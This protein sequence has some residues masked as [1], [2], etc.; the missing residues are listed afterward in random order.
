MFSVYS[1]NKGIG[2]T[3][4]I[5]LEGSVYTVG[6]YV[7]MSPTCL[8][9]IDIINILAM[10]ETCMQNVSLAQKYLSTTFILI[11][12]VKIDSVY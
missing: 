2:L 4:P 9:N 6:P 12:C 10:Y 1:K 3:V 11:K 7:V 5:L 8:A